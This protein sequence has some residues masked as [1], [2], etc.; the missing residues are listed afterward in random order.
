[1]IGI[2]MFVA[3]FGLWVC[4]K[5]EKRNISV[6]NFLRSSLPGHLTVDDFIM[7]CISNNVTS[8]AIFLTDDYGVCLCYDIDARFYCIQ[9]TGQVMCFHDNAFAKMA[10][11]PKCEKILY[12]KDKSLP[13]SLDE[14]SLWCIPQTKGRKDEAWITGEREGEWKVFTPR[15]KLQDKGFQPG[16]QAYVIKKEETRAK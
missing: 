11:R 16:P 4:H 3:M 7:R 10:L 15:P 6:R 9:Q 14:I 12:H 2:V 1:M 13:Q 5:T 8:A